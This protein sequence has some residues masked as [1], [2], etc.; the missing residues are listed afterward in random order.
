[1]LIFPGTTVQNNWA[2]NTTMMALFVQY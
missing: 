2:T 1:V